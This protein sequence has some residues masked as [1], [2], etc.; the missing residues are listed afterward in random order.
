V[1][2]IVGDNSEEFDENNNPVL[3]PANIDSGANHLAEGKIVE[4]LTTREK[5]QLSVDEWRVIRAA[6]EHGTPIPSNSREEVLLGYHYALR[7]QAKQVAKEKIEIQQRKESAIAASNAARRA[8]SDGSHTNAYRNRRHGSRYENLEYSERQSISRNLDS[9]FLS[10]NE[11]G[12]IIPKTL[13]AAQAYLFTT[14]P[15]PGDPREH[16]H[17]ASLNGLKMVGNKLSAKEEEAYH[18]KETH[19]PRSPRHHNS[20]RRRSSSRRSRSPSP[21]QHGGTRKSRS[22]NRRHGYEDDEKEIGTSC[23]TRRVRTTLVPKG[24]KLP[25][26]QQKYDGS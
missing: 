9:S 22:P 1:L 6:V 26:D 21:K 20:P 12:N 15:S 10:V 7:Q 3:N 11:H 18:K 17:R 19:K 14:R 23:F 16:M 8:R 13:E 2:T 4:S 24:F 5:V 25:H